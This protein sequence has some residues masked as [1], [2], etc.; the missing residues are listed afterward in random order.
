MAK[1]D[2][3]ALTV[4]QGIEATN[5][6]FTTLQE[7]SHA[8][9]T[10]AKL[11]REDLDG[12]KTWAERLVREG[13]VSEESVKLANEVVFGQSDALQ[14]PAGGTAFTKIENPTAT[15]MFNYVERPA[16]G[17]KPPYAMESFEPGVYL[18]P[19]FLGECYMYILAA[20]TADPDHLKQHMGELGTRVLEESFQINSLPENTQDD[21]KNLLLRDISHGPY[22]DFVDSFKNRAE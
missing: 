21:A 9:E 7:Q 17:K 12:I 22:K 6:L 20:A 18:D 13:N 11:G 2:E 5:S 16:Y 15:P 4:E 19:K 1:T 10:L 14:H 3:Q 8:N